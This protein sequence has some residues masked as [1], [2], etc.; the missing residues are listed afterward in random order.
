LLL[1]ELRAKIN[2]W[3]LFQRPVFERRFHSGRNGRKEVSEAQRKRVS[4][5]GE[6]DSLGDP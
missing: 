5:S 2:G 3:N 1:I 4:F 6:N